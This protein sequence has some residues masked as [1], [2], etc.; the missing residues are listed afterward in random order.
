[1]IGAH[2]VILGNIE[3]GDGAKVGAGS[4]VLK[5]IPPSATAVGVPARV[6]GRTQEQ[7]AG[8]TMDCALQMVDAFGKYITTTT[9]NAGVG[10]GGG[11]AGGGKRGGGGG[12]KTNK[13][14]TP[15]WHDLWAN[16]LD[17]GVH[18]KG[19]VSREELRGRLAPFGCTEAESDAVFWKLDANLDNRIDEDEF[20]ERW[21]EA[22]AA[23]CPAKLCARMRA[24]L[25]QSQDNN[26]EPEMLSVKK[27]ADFFKRESERAAEAKSGL[28]FVPD[29]S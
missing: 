20:R 27:K 16:T 21:E 11:G 7:S 8:K 22:V 10:G 18:E 1:M 28:Y 17:V 6:V 15:A 12:D 25:S 3:V 26:V 9:S 5:P 24:D 19:F 4:V 23:V 29:N 2:A 14:T 13:S